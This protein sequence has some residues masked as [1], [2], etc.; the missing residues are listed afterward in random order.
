MKEREL[1]KDYLDEYYK[2]YFK[3]NDEYKD[4]RYL[5]YSFDDFDVR[6]R[7]NKINKLKDK[8]IEKLRWK[9]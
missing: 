5:D 3:L 6:Y 8:I 2:V 9:K 4:G 7:W 1:T